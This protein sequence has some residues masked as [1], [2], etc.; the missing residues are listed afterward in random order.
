MANPFLSLFLPPQEYIPTRAHRAPVGA[1]TS[2]RSENL[3]D[4]GAVLAATRYAASM[5]G[6]LPR[7]Q[8]AR[9]AW[10]FV[11]RFIKYAPDDREQLVRLPWRTIADGEGDCKSTAVLIAALCAASG[12]DVR[13]AFAQLP[14]QDYFGHVYVLSDGVAVDPLLEFGAECLYIRRAVV[15]IAE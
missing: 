6:P 14:G 1:I 9:L 5:V 3:D 2:H 7:D 11:R 12:C 13:L 8:A 4:A 15:P 10:C